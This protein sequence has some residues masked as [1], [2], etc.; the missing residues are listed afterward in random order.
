[1]PA[2]SP[3]FNPIEQA[4][5]KLK[6]HLRAAAARTLDELQHALARALPT[7]SPTHCRNFFHDA[8]YTTNELENALVIVRVFS[9]DRAF[10]FARR[11]I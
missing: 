1:L 8:H 6:A 5:A 2:Y 3:D 7:F 4:F 9:Y 10:A 11:S